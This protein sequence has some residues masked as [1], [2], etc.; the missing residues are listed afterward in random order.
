MLR[1]HECHFEC[2]VGREF[3]VAHFY[4]YFVFAGPKTQFCAEASGVGIDFD[5]PTVDGGAGSRAVIPTTVC[6]ADVVDSS[7]PLTMCRGAFLALAPAESV[8]AAR[9]RMIFFMAGDV[10]KRSAL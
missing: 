1:L 8:S 4:V 9:R 3:P 10:V 7:A 5:G 6:A 2:G